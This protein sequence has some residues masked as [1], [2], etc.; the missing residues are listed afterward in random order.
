MGIK[1]FISPNDLWDFCLKHREILDEM[2]Q[3]VA[4][5]DDEDVE[6]VVFRSGTFR[7]AVLYNGESVQ[8]FQL[9][10]DNAVGVYR[11]ILE[12]YIYRA[13]ETFNDI[14]DQETS[15]DDRENELDDAVYDLLTGV[16]GENFDTNSLETQ[17][18]MERIKDVVCEVLHDEFN[19]DVYRPMYLAGDDG[20]REYYA[21]PYSEMS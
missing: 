21:Y 7:A 16:L 17:E 3:T 9:M 18:M 19:L 6:I 4:V 8:D 15:I 11:G 2:P 14:V 20:V 10:P 13:A 5:N 12:M 1:V